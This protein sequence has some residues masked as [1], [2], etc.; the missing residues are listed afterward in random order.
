METVIPI[1]SI[2]SEKL[3]LKTITPA[4]FDRPN[5]SAAREKPLDRVMRIKYTHNVD[6][7]RVTDWRENH[8]LERR[9]LLQG[10]HSQ[11]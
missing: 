2:F 8:F 1:F 9:I 10:L 7:P 3:L 11:L 5:R 4:D 6:I